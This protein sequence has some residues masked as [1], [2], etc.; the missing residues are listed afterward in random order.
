MVSLTPEEAFRFLR[1]ASVAHLGV[2][3][4]EKPYV[5]PMSFVMHGDRILFRTQA[6]RKFQAI[7]ENPS[8]CL[9]ASSFDEGTG[10]WVSVIIRGTAVERSDQATA[11][12]TIA[13]LLEKYA[14]QI[15]S[16]F[17]RSGLQPMASLPHVVEV[18]IDEI[19][20]MSSGTGFTPRT[21]PGRL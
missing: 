21:R 10:D 5:T 15:G 17:G 19:S 4:E 3:S 12:L 18:M 13:M 1:E 14:A 11:E 8:V 16:L 20:G 9:E 7:A 2:I 6:G